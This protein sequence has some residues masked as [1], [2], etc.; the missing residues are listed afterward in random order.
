VIDGDSRRRLLGIARAAITAHV[1]GRPAPE[2]P[3][4]GCLGRPAGAFVTLRTAGELRGCI[5]RVEAVEALARVVAHV[6]VAACSADP[7]FEAVRPHELDALALE[8]SVL[9]ALEA[10][11]APVD[12]HIGRHGIVIEQGRRRGLLLPQ[13]AVE[14]GWDAETFLAQT[15][16]KAGL[17]EDVWRRGASVWRFEAEVFGDPADG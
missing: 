14:Y 15:C 16:V 8:I 6:A 1:H 10:V 4:E 13:V 7:R 12:I 2:A 3:C 5:G 9:G 11:A 17:Q